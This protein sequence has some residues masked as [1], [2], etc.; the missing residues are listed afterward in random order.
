MWG[1]MTSHKVKKLYAG[2]DNISHKIKKAYIGDE[3]GRS[4]LFF[5]SG[6][7][8]EKYNMNISLVRSTS[9][10]SA[11]TNTEL[12]PLGRPYT[13]YLSWSAS[14][15]VVATPNGVRLKSYNTTPFTTEATQG[16]SGDRFSINAYPYC[17]CY[18]T[19][20]PTGSTQVIQTARKVC[21]TADC[22]NYS[23]Q[24]WQFIALDK[25]YPLVVREY[26]TYQGSLI[27]TVE[28][29]NPSAYPDNGVHTDGYWYK[30]IQ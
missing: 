1:G 21:L 3:T 30:R 26:S 18:D 2:I 19:T 17:Q 10:I 5:S 12:K 25:D 24:M 27:G 11:G 22:Y 20:I 8:W 15:D 7:V 28:S 4:R 14:P 9:M 16:V 23:Y 6:Y 13:V 29:D